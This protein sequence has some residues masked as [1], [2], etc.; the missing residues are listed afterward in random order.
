MI[1]SKQSHVVEV[2]ISSPLKPEAFLPLAIRVAAALDCWHSGGVPH[3]SLTPHQI[4]VPA[5]PSGKI[6]LVEQRGTLHGQGHVAGYTPLAGS[7][8][9]LAYMSPERIRGLGQA[10]DYRADLYSIG[11]IFYEMLTGQTPFQASDPLEWAHCHIARLPE[12]PL[13]IEQDLPRPLADIVMKL[14]HKT[15]EERYQSAAGLKRDL[16]FCLDQWRAKGVWESFPLGA[17]DAANQL[18]LPHRLYGREQDIE[19]M[20]QSFERVATSGCPELVLISG[21]S[22]IGKTSLVWELFKPVIRR[23]GFFLWGKFD[24]L[25]R[26]IPYSTLIEAFEELVRRLLTKEER[27]LAQWRDRLQQ[28]LGMNG[29]LIVDIIPQLELIVGHQPP[30]TEL[31]VREAENRFRTVFLRFIDVFA[32]KNHPLV[33]FL[34]DLQ[35]ADSASLGL[36]EY[37][38]TQQRTHALLIIGAYRDN[39]VDPNHPLRHSLDTIT[40]SGREIRTIHLQPL[41]HAHLCQLLAD[42]LHADHAHVDSLARLIYEKTIG[43]AFFSIQLLKTLHGEQLLKVDNGSRNWLWDIKAIQAKGYADNVVD[44]MVGNLKKLRPETQGLLQTASCIGNSFHLADLASISRYSEEKVR[45]ILREAMQNSLLHFNPMEDTYSFLHDRIQQSAYSL[46]PPN[47]RQATHLEI[48]RRMLANLPQEVIEERI[49]DIV[50]QFNLGSTALMDRDERYRIAQLNLIAGHRSNASSAYDLALTSFAQGTRL[51]DEAGWGTHY[52]LMFNLRKELAVALYVN[53]D[54]AE[55]QHQIDILLQWAKTDLQRAELLNILIIEYTLTGRYH[56]ALQT[57]KEGLLLLGE[58]VSLDRASEE[59]S[60]QLE[61]YREILGE[62]T[63][64]S[65]AEEPE[66][67]D[68]EKRIALELLSNMVVPARYTDN[69]LF[70][71]VS[72]LNVNHSLRYGPTPKSTVG[73]TS[74]GMFLNSVKHQFKEAYAFGNLALRIGERFKSPA[75]TCQACFMLGHYL[76]HWVEPLEQSDAFNN[77]GIAAGLA[78]GE[79]QWTGYIQAYKLFQPFYRGRE[80]KLLRDEAP[81]LLSFTGKTSNQWASDTLRGFQLI[82]DALMQSDGKGLLVVPEGS[83]AAIVDERDYL[84]ACEANRSFGALGRYQVLKVQLLHLY[85]RLPE[86]RKAMTAA[87]GLLGYYSSSVSVPALCF[88]SSLVLAASYDQAS[89]SVQ[90]EIV[91]TLEHNLARFQLWVAHSPDNFTPLNRLIEAEYARITGKELIAAKLFDQAILEAAAR[92]V[93]QY[94]ALANETAARFFLHNGLATAAEPYLIR[95]RAGYQRWGAAGKVRQMERQFPWLKENRNGKV[96]NGAWPNGVGTMDALAVVKASQAISQEIVLSNLATILMR[97]VLEHAGAQRGFLLCEHDGMP[98]VEAEAW[99]DGANITIHQPEHIQEPNEM[100]L[101]LSVLN[102][103][104]RSHEVVLVDD[105]SSGQRF[106]NDPYISKTRPRS[107]LCL[108]ILR[109]TRLIGILYLENNLVRGAFS[110]DRIVALEVLA[111]QA[112]I[113]L[114]NAELYKEREKVEAALRNSESKYKTLFDHSGAAL[115]FIEEDMSISMVN[116]EFESLFGYRRE[117]VEGKLPWTELVATPDDLERMISYHQLRR[118]NPGMAP[119]GYECRVRHRQGS[120]LDVVATVTMLPGTR[121][122]LAAVLDMSE[123]KRVETEHLRLVTAIEQ[124][125]EAVFITDTDFTILYANPAF[126]RMCGYDR[127]EIIGLSTR[128]LEHNKH[129]RGFYQGIRRALGNG[130]VW[131]GQMTCTRKDGSSYE[132]EVVASP[133]FDKQGH[134]INFVGTHKDVTHE[135]KL[136]EELRQAQKMEAIG[137]LAGGIAHDFNNILTSIMGNAEMIHNNLPPGTRDQERLQHLLTACNRAADLVQQILT[138]SRKTKAERNP[139]HLVPIVKETVKLLRST[140]PTTIAIRF[141][142]ASDLDTD[143]V[144]ADPTQIHQILMNLATNAAHT[145]GPN[146]GILEI[147]LTS[148]EVNGPTGLIVPGLAARSYLCLSVSDTGQGM[149]PAVVQ[150]IFE[151]YFTTKDVGKGTGLGLAVVKGIVDSY[152]GGITV[153]SVPGCG[154]TFRI[155]FQTAQVWEETVAP[156]PILQPTGRGRILL[157]D[158]EEVLVQ[159]GIDVLTSLGYEVEGSSNS[160]EALQRFRDRP[161]DFDLLL[162]DMTMPGLTGKE[163]AEEILALRPQ[164]PVVLCTGFSEFI[165]SHQAEEQGIRAF[166]QKPYTVAQIGRIIQQ[167]LDRKN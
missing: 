141:S 77:Q 76:S 48:G 158:D 46:I 9:P 18:Y 125:D 51:T 111:A 20:I 43:N 86:A 28:A 65:L 159:L 38:F 105:A 91:A 115:M 124:I 135:L 120:V 134:I 129:E 36:L 64:E 37:I 94:E 166:V 72:L 163:L 42:T 54:Y 162:T 96:G 29:Q 32:Q 110:K 138:F 35:W 165:D 50:N 60:E 31:P 99:V 44:L 80:L 92:N 14:L 144:L 71:L 113:S 108:P 49:F 61:V 82:I 101:P 12:S 40:L 109:Q 62:R 22:G 149:E 156:E 88:H 164:I 137:T 117:E 21:Y 10:V 145:I 73:Y 114:E 2:S 70:A 126:E 19:K 118:S 41:S 151:P 142:L 7:L 119:Q 47:Q 131:S 93:M 112:A 13:S 104:L 30:V 133:V 34:D 87:E 128:R 25:N 59:L 130:T 136:E 56:D 23:H 98:M 69:T 67:T 97:T 66:M 154:T 85:G 79:M 122:S 157:V 26:N 17:I 5:D 8:E 121:Q 1:N 45:E 161:D 81:D 78:S 3:G 84:A 152:K 103:V 53:S 143:T 167:I 27:N 132:A 147:A 102:Y 4:L 123:R 74:F 11:A 6:L 139:I 106:Q 127:H 90:N 150:R 89:T 63:I 160:Q 153:D 148:L 146:T 24:Q 140:L 16:E 75:Q 58:K 155:F 68:P 95:A 33:L 15:V 83:E 57:G 52:A 100:D 39:E 107:L 116:K 55:S